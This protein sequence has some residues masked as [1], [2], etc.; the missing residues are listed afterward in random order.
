M[1]LIEAAAEN[2]LNPL[3]NLWNSFVLIFPKLIVAVVILIVG[4]ILALIIGHVVRIAIFK[5]G[6]DKALFKYTKLP[7]AI[8][9]IKVSSVMGQ[10][11]KWYIFIIFIQAA[12]DAV[13]L[14]T[15]SVLLA[16]FALWL[17][18]LIVAVLAVLLGLFLAHYLS[19]LLERESQ[20]KGIKYISSM[21]KVMIMFI[22]IVIALEQIG[23]EVSILQN[24]FLIV[25]ASIGLGVALAIGLAFGLGM[26]DK[27]NGIYES[28]KK[29]F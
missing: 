24:T 15:L 28:V 20:M 3:V 16:K 21:F 6:V 25:I 23:I 19:N 22:A 17:P 27:A 14:G 9:K 1:A 8:G 12:V 13:D 7:P 10:I 4:Y 29:N 18:Q 26:K 5:M 2:M 11:T